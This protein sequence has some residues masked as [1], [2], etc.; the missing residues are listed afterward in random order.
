MA[1]PALSLAQ[2]N[3][4]E[5]VI[6]GKL[7]GV[8]APAKVYLRYTVDKKAITD[9]AE[10]K[11]G[12]FSFRK[13]ATQ[14]P[15]QAY[16]V[17]NKMGNGIS[18]ARDYA[19]IYLEK[20]TIN[21][22]GTADG[23]AKADIGG[24]PTNEDFKVLSQQLKPAEAISAE[25]SKN[26]KNASATQRDSETFKASQAA[27]E[28]RYEELHNA[29]LVKFIQAHPASY[30]SLEQLGTLAYY[31]DYAETAP[32]YEG[33]ATGIKESAPGKKFASQLTQMKTVAI[34]ATAP[35][36]ALPDTAGKVVSLASFKGK[37]VLVDLWASWC[38]P[39]RAENPNLVR[40]FNKFKGQN[41][42]ILGVSLDRPA[43]R[44]KW[45]AAIKKDELTWTHVSDLKF[46]DNEV[47]Q[48]YG[49][50]AIPQNFLLDPSGK[51]IA[52]NL[53]GDQLDEKLTTLFL[54]KK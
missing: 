46:W 35:L 22:V 25:Y 7:R 52:K 18:G 13:N 30:L 6:T 10:V 29:V 11:E 43:D 33:L 34:G 48:L 2:V 40:T 19:Q 3:N 20:G 42:T 21:V 27:L 31:L 24:T 28:K 1:A 41:F 49:V 44:T 54:V 37:Y 8:D 45:M 50:K 17:L 14:V 5:C 12:G 16:L 36:F 9:S 53:R 51:I 15:A 47:A 39:C 4:S 26:E 38:G 23:M 32:L